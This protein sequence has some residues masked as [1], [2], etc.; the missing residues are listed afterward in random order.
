M[1]EEQNGTVETPQLGF[2]R[3]FFSLLAFIALVAG[4]YGAYT[5][6]QVERVGE[7]ITGRVLRSE[8][9]VDPNYD[10]DDVGDGFLYAPVVEFSVNGGTITFESANAVYP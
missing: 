9:Q 1:A 2:T 7:T 4:L 3:S 6:W 10:P 5:A 8:K